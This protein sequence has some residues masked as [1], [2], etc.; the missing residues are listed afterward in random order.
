[1][2]KRY[3]VF[4]SSTF[5]DLQEERREIMMALL[6][7]NCLPAGMELFPAADEDQW[8]YI[9]TVI[10]DSDYYVVIIGGRYGSTDSAGVSFTEKEYDYALSK[11]KPVIAF[12]HAEPEN[13][14]KNK[15]EKS[16]DAEA[17]LEKFKAKVKLK[18][19]KSWTTA[20]E[21][22]GLFSRSLVQLQKSHPAE[23]WVRGRFASNAERLIELN[24]HIRQLQDEIEQI[25]IKAPAGAEELASGSEKFTLHNDYQAADRKTKTQKLTLTWDQIISRIGPLMFVRAS[26]SELIKS[27]TDLFPDPPDRYQYSSGTTLSRDDFHTIISQLRVLGI[28]VTSIH[29]TA[30]KNP[31][32]FWALTPYGEQCVLKLK[33]VKKDILGDLA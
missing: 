16:P 2:D 7:L 29:K 31:G 15:T 19:C 21:L 6:E 3:Q 14:P 27:L 26:E 8:S 9:K 11:G 10:D 23:G 5:V 33:A 17:R 20:K 4:V 24:S 1:M 22:G 18:L 28:I 12:V 25:R 30:A 32:V 13:L